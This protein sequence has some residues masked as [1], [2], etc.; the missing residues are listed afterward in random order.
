MFRLIK[1][2]YCASTFA[3]PNASRTTRLRQKIL[4]NQPGRWKVRLNRWLRRAGPA[5]A[6]ASLGGALFPGHADRMPNV[7]S[8][9]PPHGASVDPLSTGWPGWRRRLAAWRWR[10][11][12]TAASVELAPVAITAAHKWPGQAGASDKAKQEEAHHTSPSF[13]SLALRLGWSSSGSSSSWPPRASC[14]TRRLMHSVML[15]SPSSR[16][17]RAS[18]M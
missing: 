3:T 7:A 2:Y 14:L 9:F 18:T 15:S 5:V 12:A 6:V 13:R 11:A 1:S 17:L 8:L 10:V 4:S 16:V